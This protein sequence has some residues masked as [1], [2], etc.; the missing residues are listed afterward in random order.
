[1]S[2]TE[3]WASVPDAH[4]YLVSDEGQVRRMLPDGTWRWLRATRNRRAYGDDGY[5][6]VC[7]GRRR[8]EYVHRL[9]WMAFR[10]VIP[11]DMQVDHRDQDR[12]NNSLPNLQ[13]VSDQENKELRWERWNTDPDW[14][15]SVATQHDEEAVA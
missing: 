13:L 1:V 15:D 10:G 6:K 4:E 5:L 8:Q 11:D 9:V 14:P 7:L 3:R 12:D 2:D